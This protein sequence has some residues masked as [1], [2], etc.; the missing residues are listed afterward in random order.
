M[1]KLDMNKDPFI[2]FKGSWLGKKLKNNRVF[3][4]CYCFIKQFGKMSE[5]IWNVQKGERILFFEKYGECNPDKHFYYIRA[6]AAEGFFAHYRE[7]VYELMVAESLNCIPVVEWN[8][9]HFWYADK[10]A[11]NLESPYDYFF[12]QPGKISLREMK[13]SKYVLEAS[14]EHL[15][16]ANAE[17][18]YKKQNSFAREGEII[19]KFLHPT[20]I[21]QKHIDNDLRRM[22][23]SKRIIGIHFRGGD[24]KVG[25]KGHP[26]YVT[27]EQTY[28]ALVVMMQETG[29]KEV[30]LATDDQNALCYFKEKLG[31]SL[32][33]YDDTDR[34]DNDSAVSTYA[35]ESYKLGLDVLRDVYT[36]AICTG[37][38]SGLS[39]VGWA[40]AAINAAWYKPFEQR[41]VLDNGTN[42]FGPAV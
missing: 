13:N 38:I 6:K 18:Q 12:E 16:L 30:F 20:L 4:A 15:P 36:L 21:V 17:W 9:K 25:Y 34:V 35:G 14:L 29:I 32:F 27:A 42:A 39:N 26:V 23:L 24:Y 41:V 10:S 5:L 19:K 22:L 40:A 7:L 2:Q 3:Y 31:N 1:P 8:E 33:Y 28:N 37:L 11:N